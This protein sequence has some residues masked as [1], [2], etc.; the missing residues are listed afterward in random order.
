MVEKDDK[1]FKRIDSISHSV[2]GFNFERTANS[3]KSVEINPNRLN[4]NDVREFLKFL[5]ALNNREQKSL[6]FLADMSR[7]R[8]DQLKEKHKQLGAQLFILG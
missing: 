3:S 2:Y 7:K 6:Q 1:A 4:L 8:I 5:A